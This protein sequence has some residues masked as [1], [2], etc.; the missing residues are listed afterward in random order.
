MSIG[1]FL[2]LGFIPQTSAVSYRRKIDLH[3]MPLMCCEFDG[4]DLKT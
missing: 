4:L 1:D 2:I 3:L